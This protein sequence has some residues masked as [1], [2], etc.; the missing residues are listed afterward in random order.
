MAALCQ[1][2]SLTLWEQWFRS[3]SPAQRQQLVEQ[4]GAQ[5]LLFGHQ[6]PQ[7]EPHPIPGPSSL[8]P[9]LL[10][11]RSVR[12]EPVREQTV[13]LFFDTALDAQQRQA[14]ARALA[15]PDL[16]LILG[17]PGCGKSRVA[18]E[19]LRQALRRRWRTLFMAPSPAAVD[20]VLEQLPQ[21]EALAVLRWHDER[22]PVASLPPLVA[23]LTLAGRLHSLEEQTL[24]VA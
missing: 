3:A 14:L 13:D 19:L 4:S 15:S 22:E 7:P 2:S 18:V 1:A 16:S 10:T 20:C 8:L 17:Y 6:L 11:G 9:D 24:P 21:G 12:L 5:G 23:S